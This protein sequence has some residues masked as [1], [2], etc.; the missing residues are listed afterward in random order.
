LGVLAL[1]WPYRLLGFIPDIKKIA[2]SRDYGWDQFR[3]SGIVLSYAFGC[4]FSGVV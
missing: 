2:N 1:Q 4:D 3:P